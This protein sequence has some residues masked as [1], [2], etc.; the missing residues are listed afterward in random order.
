MGVE[1]K[2]DKDAVYALKRGVDKLADAVK[3]TLGPNGRNVIINA[4]GIPHITKDG[5]TVAKSIALDD[6]FENMG[7][8]LIKDIA[9]K[10]CDD[11]GDGT[12][13]S[14]V[15]AQAIITHG[16]KAVEDGANPMLVKSEIDKSVKYIV[17]QIKL[18]AQKATNDDLFSIATISANGDSE[19]GKI[20]AEAVLSVGENGILT[21]DESNTSETYIERGSGIKIDRGYI[22]P[23]FAGENSEEAILND[24]ILFMI[25][26][27]VTDIN[28][29]KSPMESAIANNKSILIICDD[30]GGQALKSVIVNKTRGGLNACV[31]TAPGIGVR[32]RDILEDIATATGSKVYD[33]GEK[34]S[35]LKLIER[36]VVNRASTTL[37]GV[38]GDEVKIAD[39]VQMLKAQIDKAEPGIESD[40]LRE[41]LSMLDGGASILK[42]G[43]NSE[44]ELKEKI[45]RIDDAINAVRSAISEGIVPG[46]GSMFLSLSTTVESDVLA[47]SLVEPFRLLC[48]NSGLNYTSLRNNILL[49][50][51][52][53]EYGYNFKT[54]KF[55]N[56]IQSGVVDPAKVLRVSLENAASVAGLFLTTACVISE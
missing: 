12:T 6:V 28:D 21:V 25:N 7:A 33:G 34:V 15:L 19:I 10:T 30:M 8:Q 49:S 32:R 17:E 47:N 13:S 24:C 48:E 46:G 23:I 22:S 2:F 50:S 41:R 45:D 5:V 55:E 9:S 11:A 52:P 39:R 29:I 40:K 14:S 36:V 56:L 44:F 1:I 43:A 53:C 42:V 35:G 4:G 54:N 37:L 20:V 26:K 38:K 3:V 31:I 27:K 51:N 16:L 18:K